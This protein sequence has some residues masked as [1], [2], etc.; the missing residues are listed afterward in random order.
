MNLNQHGGACRCLLRLLENEGRPGIPDK[1]F[2][3]R[4][5][6]RYPAWLECPGFTDALTIFE[7]AKELELAASIEISRDYD[8]VLHEHQ[9]GHAILV[10][11]ERTP[12]QETA[13]GETRRQ[14]ALL[15]DISATDF[16]LWCPFESGASDL[17]PRAARTWW[18]TWSAIGIILS[19][20]GP[21]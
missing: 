21:A 10:Q 6:P 11:T 13:S 2:L 16:M 3:T 5:L 9:V 8:R 4:F 12:V 19:K 1:V 18:E 15:E 17:L 14:V 20:G 7:L